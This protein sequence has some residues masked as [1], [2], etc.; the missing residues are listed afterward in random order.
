MYIRI[1]IY[2]WKSMFVKNLKIKWYGLYFN[3]Y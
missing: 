2:N 3:S 1:V